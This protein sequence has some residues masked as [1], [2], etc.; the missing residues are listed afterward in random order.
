[1]MDKRL[2]KIRKKELLEILLEQAKKIEELEKE[3]ERTQKKWNSKRIIIEE[4]GSL[5]EA[6]LMLNNIF[7][8]AQQTADQYLFNVKE[9]CKRMELDTK[10]A[11]QLERENMLKEVH[12]LSN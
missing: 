10:K 5:A 6:S 2:R 7:E 11:C 4:A 12:K 3:L 1:M 8:T 9:K